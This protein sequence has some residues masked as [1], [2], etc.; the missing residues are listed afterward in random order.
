MDPKNRRRH[1]RIY[2]PIEVNFNF[3][4]EIFS[5]HTV[6]LSMGGLYVKTSNPLEV[7]SIFP[8]D[9]TLPDYDHTFNVTGKVIW[10]K[11][12]ED[13]NGPP[14][15]GIKFMD[16]RPQDKDALLHFLVRTQVTYKGY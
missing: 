13:K 12:T 3:E 1:P 9:F 7:G 10:K 15:M 16:A 11:T 14:G 8:L 5:E 4:N 2:S 6:S